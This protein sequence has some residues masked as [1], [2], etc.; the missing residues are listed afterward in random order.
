MKQNRVINNGTD[1]L[2]RYFSSFRGWVLAL[3][4]RHP[5]PSS[6]RAATAEASSAA[7]AA[8]KIGQHHADTSR[9]PIIFSSAA[10]PLHHPA[11]PLF[12]HVPLKQED[13]R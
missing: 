10:P 12:F 13:G 6:G 4:V 8:S 2:R 7:V 3:L 11:D 9:K 1:V 5:G